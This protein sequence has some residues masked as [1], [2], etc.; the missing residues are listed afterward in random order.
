MNFYSPVWTSDFNSCLAA[1]ESN[2]G[3]IDVSYIPSSPNQGPC[4]M[5]NSLQPAFTNT[6]VWGAKRSSICPDLDGT[7]Y[8]TSCGSTYQIQCYIDHFGGLLDTVWTSSLKSCIS[9]CDTA[10]GCVDVSYAPGTL[11][12]CYLKNSIG[13][14]SNNTGILGAEQLTACTS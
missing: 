10:T 4:Y 12:P 5:K 8:Q 13:A 3:C 14:A 9:A 6:H 1:C 2:P 7:T 11:G